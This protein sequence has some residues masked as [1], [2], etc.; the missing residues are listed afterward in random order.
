MRT[1]QYQKKTQENPYDIVRRILSEELEMN[2]TANNTQQQ[3]VAQSTETL[4]HSDNPD[5]QYIGK[6]V[7]ELKSKL[8]TYFTLCANTNEWT[9]DAVSTLIEMDNTLSVK[10]DAL[11]YVSNLNNSQAISTD[12]I[13][14]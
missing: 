11:N 10:I 8:D 13:S 7:G 12:V 4:T 9:R 3:S 5:I 14:L 6:L 1:T 2:W